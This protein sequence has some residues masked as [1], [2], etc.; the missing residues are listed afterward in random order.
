MTR[1]GWHS[2]GYLPHFDGEETT[3]FVTFRLADALPRERLD[4]WRSQ[5]RLL[6]EWRA[7]TE[8]HERIERYL[9]TGAGSALLREPRFAAMVEHRLRYSDGEQYDLD[10]WV[11]GTESPDKR[12]REA[13]APLSM[14]ISAVLNGLALEV[15]SDPDLDVT[16]AF[17]LWQEFVM[18]YLEKVQGE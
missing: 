7:K 18:Q 1:R 15:Q 3:Q 4:A 12:E 11:V 16:P 8:L 2:R 6:P 5:L 17:D 14:L 10:A 9:D 13:L